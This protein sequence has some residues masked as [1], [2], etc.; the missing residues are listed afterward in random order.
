LAS[1]TVS[2]WL[3]TKGPPVS[4]NQDAE[5]QWGAATAHGN[6]DR[7]TETE[8]T[9]HNPLASVRA[10]GAAAEPAGRPSVYDAYAGRASWVQWDLTEPTL[11]EEEERTQAGLT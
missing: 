6:A 11:A 10:S 2:A 4:G 9:M 1:S 8:L 7:L 5:A 3:V